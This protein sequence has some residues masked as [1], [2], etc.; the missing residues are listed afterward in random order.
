MIKNLEA[1]FIDRDGTLG[2]T[3]RFIHPNNFTLY[4]T[5][6][7]ALELLQKKNIKIFA[8]TNQHRISLGEVKIEDFENEFKSLA[9]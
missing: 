6:K 8:F 7:I 9:L 3:G 2:G 5:S 4:P 1:V